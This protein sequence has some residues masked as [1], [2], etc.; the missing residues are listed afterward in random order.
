[1]PFHTAFLVFLTAQR[2]QCPKTIKKRRL[3]AARLFI[4][5][6]PDAGDSVFHAVPNVSCTWLGHRPGKIRLMILLFI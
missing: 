5:D 3:H 6:L 2:A 4:P 1:M